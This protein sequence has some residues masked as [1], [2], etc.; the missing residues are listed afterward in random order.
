[1]TTELEVV[2]HYRAENITARVL[3]ALR[4]VYGPDAPITPDLLAP[5]D[6]FHGM[7]LVATRELGSALKPKASDHL[8]DIG[9]GI[10]GPARW[11]AA[12]FGCR[13]TGVDLTESFCEAARQ[14]TSLAGLA[15][16][17]TILHG[18]ALS[19]PMPDASFDAA[20]SQA[21][22]M[23]ISDKLG[24][25]LEAFR[26]LRPGGMLGISLVGP[27]P[28]GEPYYPLPW[29]T[30]QASS[31][32]ATPDQ[33][34]TELQAGG[35]EILSLHDTTVATIETFSPIL[36]RLE[37][38]GLPPLGEHVVTGENAR[39]WRINAMRSLGDRRTSMIEVLARKPA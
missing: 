15:D 26:V 34:R 30:T 37:T 3:A 22:L 31:F 29:A 25:A 18:S 20:Y 11:F 2:Q 9:C 8:L 6:H 23:N 32:L 39:E 7:G 19:L 12:R 21:V 35:F 14:L 1:M 13:V 16:R 24:F 17:V 38:E 5:I 36:K 10:G 27:G 4:A 33:I 28:V